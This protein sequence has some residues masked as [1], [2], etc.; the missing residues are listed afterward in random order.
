MP[1]PRQTLQLSLLVAAILA[2]TLSGCLFRSGNDNL[3]A[4]KKALRKNQSQREKWMTKGGL[5]YQYSLSY[6]ENLLSPGGYAG[7]CRVAPDT[8]FCDLVRR[9]EEYEIVGRIS[10]PPVIEVF[11]ERIDSLI[12]KS[13]PPSLF[14]PDPVSDSLRITRDSLLYW[15]LVPDSTREPPLLWPSGVVAVYDS[16]RGF[17]RSILR[18]PLGPSFEIENF[19]EIPAE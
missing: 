7:T 6:R 14:A 1:T 18:A 15:V 9:D 16:A 12:A 3:S 17:P 19:E 4:D 2:A 5:Y 8:S 11:F 13:P 10:F